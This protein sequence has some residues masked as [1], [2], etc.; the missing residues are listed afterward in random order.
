MRVNLLSSI[1]LEKGWEAIRDYEGHTIFRCPSV[2]KPSYLIIPNQDI[3]EVPFGTLNTAARQAHRWKETDHWSASFGKRK[4]LPMILERQDATFWGRIEIPG[5]LA[6]S[7]GCGPDCV[8][9]RLRSV[10]LEFAAN[11]APEVC[12]T[13]QKIPF[14]SVY[15]TSALWEVFRQLKT[16]YLAHQSGI[17]PDLIGQFMTG[18]THPCDELAKRLETS[19]HELGRQ[20]MQ[21]SIR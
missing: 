17:D 5:L 8:A 16:S 10:W 12:A 14:V 7:Q 6:I 11:D 9:D 13:L 2:L 15:D 3:D 1:V 21:V 4:S 18:S 20:L 19:I